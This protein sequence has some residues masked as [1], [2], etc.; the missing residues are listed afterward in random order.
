M[1]PDADPIDRIV[2]RSLLVTEHVRTVSVTW[3][4]PSNLNHAA[5]SAAMARSAELV[6]DVIHMTNGRTSPGANI[7]VRAAF[8]S[9]LVGAWALFGGRNALIGIERERARNERS[10]AERNG[11]PD[12]DLK[13]IDRQI[14]TL[15]GVATRV[16]GTE[17]PSS[18]SYERIATALA[19]L[20]K[21]Q[22]TD[23]E[24]ADFLAI[25]DLLYRSHS[26]YDAHPWKIIGRYLEETGLGF[27]VQPVKPWQDGRMSAAHM[28]MYIAILG[29]WIEQ[30]R[31]GSGDEWSMLAEPL[32]D[33]LQRR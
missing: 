21:A 30:A 9:W 13:R 4:F 11:M 19:P 12:E 18:V 26:T 5:A 16:L 7:V 32:A 14:E 33:L 31:G 24:D 10:L 25:Y 17:A 29:R 28:A 1:T 3:R 8:E 6:E 15:K 23:E 27:K 22:T 20:V 2:D